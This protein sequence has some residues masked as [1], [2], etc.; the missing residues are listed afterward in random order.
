MCS[1]MVIMP[2]DEGEDPVPMVPLMW[3]SKFV[4]NRWEL[5]LMYCPSEAAVC[6]P[7]TLCCQIFFFKSLSASFPLTVK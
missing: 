6:Q 7:V 4:R 3:E 2:Q 5:L 1:V